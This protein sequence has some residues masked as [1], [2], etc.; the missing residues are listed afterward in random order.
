MVGALLA[1]PLYLLLLLN[2]TN[3]NAENEEDGGIHCC[4]GLLSLHRCQILCAL[5]SLAL[6]LRC[7]CV[8]I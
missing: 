7:V 3:T 5:A 1:L 2:N 4:R 8:C 6:V